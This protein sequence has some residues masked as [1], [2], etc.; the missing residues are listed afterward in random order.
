MPTYRRCRWPYARSR[1]STRRRTFTG[2]TSHPGGGPWDRPVPVKGLGLGPTPNPYRKPPNTIVGPL[3]LGVG[4]LISPAVLAIAF[5]VLLFAFLAPKPPR[6]QEPDHIPEP[7]K[8]VTTSPAVPWPLRAIAALSY[9]A[10]PVALWQLL[11]NSKS[12]PN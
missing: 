4:S 12:A 6:N 2:N 9:L 10:T 8:K 11:T 1:R 7:T 3:L 5:V